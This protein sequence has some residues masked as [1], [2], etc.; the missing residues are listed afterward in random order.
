MRVD[1][2]RYRRSDLVHLNVDL[3]IEDTKALTK[4]YTFMRVF[5]LAP[6]WELREYVCQVILDDVY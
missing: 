3:T 1:V 4:P 2:E 5:T 6:A